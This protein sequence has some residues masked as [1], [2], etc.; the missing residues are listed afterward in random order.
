MLSSSSSS[1]AQ[2]AVAASSGSRKRP[3]CDDGYRRHTPSA[4][5]TTQVLKTEP[6]LALPCSS[7][8][9]GGATAAAATTTAATTT[10]AIKDGPPDKTLLDME[11]TVI[12]REEQILPS[13][14][15]ALASLLPL[16]DSCSNDDPDEYLMMLLAVLCPNT[17]FQVQ[18]ALELTHYFPST[19]SSSTEEQTG[20]YNTDIVQITR[21]N[22]VTALRQ[23]C[24]QHG[25]TAFDCYN[26]F[27]EGLLN[28]TCRRGFTEMVEFLLSPP[29]QL[30]VRV[31]DDCGR[32][33]LHDACWNPTPQLEICTWILQKDPSLFLVADKRGYTPFQYARKSDWPIWRQFLYQHWEC[34]LVMMTQPDIR[35]TFSKKN[36][37]NR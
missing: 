24:T 29:V 37:M 5:T 17:P 28:M 12:Q 2:E 18:P 20:R 7:S 13:P 4:T 23:Y 22:D 1:S 27:G 33:P 9:S 35:T 8:S 32:T 15:R 10:D 21:T 30:P 26:R 11:S 6:P 16:P 14:P 36:E 34:L 31:R 3:R 25:P 19:T